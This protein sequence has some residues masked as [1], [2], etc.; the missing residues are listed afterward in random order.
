MTAKRLEVLRHLHKN[1]QASIAAWA[2]NLGRD[3]RLVHEDVDIL[4]RAGLIE[5][6]ADGLS[7]GYD[8]IRTVISL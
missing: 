1:P 5:Q 6:D 7:T 8:E 4:G 2:R 3:Y